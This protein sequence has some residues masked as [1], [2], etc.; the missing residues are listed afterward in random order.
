M[1]GNLKVSC[2]VSADGS[3]SSWS[4]CHSTRRADDSGHDE[5]P[6]K[7]PHG[8]ASAARPGGG[9]LDVE[10]SSTFPARTQVFWLAVLIRASCR[11]AKSAG[12]RRKQKP[13]NLKE[14]SE[15]EVIMMIEY[16]RP[17]NVK[18]LLSKVMWKFCCRCR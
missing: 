15:P 16:T 1:K 11:S 17:M 10:N 5:A 7:M 14:L 6:I 2:Y 4:R 12:I 13:V 8:G 9:E 18:W 3:S